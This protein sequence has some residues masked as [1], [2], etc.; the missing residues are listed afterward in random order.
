MTLTL[1]V[2]AFMAAPITAPPTRIG[3][4]FPLAE[5]PLV[6]QAGGKIAKLQASEGTRVRKGQL[7]LSLD[8]GRQLAE[9]QLLESQITH[10]AS[11]RLEQ[12]NSSAAKQD[13][14]RD[15]ALYADHTLSPKTLDDTRNRAKLAAE[16]VMIEQGR[17]D[18]QRQAVAI[19]RR[20]LEE[21]D[22]RSPADGVLASVLLHA[23]QV[24]GQG[25]KVGELLRLDEVIVETFV[26]LADA[27][28]LNL[29]AKAR[30]EGGGAPMTGWIKVIGEKVDPVSSSIKIKIQVA[31]PG[32]RLKPGMIVKVIL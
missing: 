1:L 9:I 22:V 27:R 30:I 16:R 13:L 21:L 25:A 31:N 2:I 24:V 18:E 6:T 28:R 3:T 14:T 4:V 10:R 32:H 15:E 5:I 20:A 29:R 17:L 7:L 19:K 23:N 8:K 26:P 11:L 12:L